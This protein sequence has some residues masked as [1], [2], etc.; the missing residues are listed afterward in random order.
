ML[1]HVEITCFPAPGDVVFAPRPVGAVLLRLPT[2]VWDRRSGGPYPEDP[3]VP[4][5]PADVFDTALVRPG[6]GL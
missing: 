6:E 1:H 5:R 2:V 4:N 3:V